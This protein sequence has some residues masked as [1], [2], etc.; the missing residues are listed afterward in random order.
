MRL[1][2]LVRRA[3]QLVEQA[4]ETLKRATDA[5]GY[6]R[7][8]PS[9]DFAALR[10]AAL[11]FIERVFGR[12]HPH[13]REFD[14]SVEDVNHYYVERALGILRAVRDEL[15]GGWLVTA[16]GLIS[17]EVFADFLEMAE[18]LLEEDYKDAAAVMIGSVLEEHLRQ[19]ASRE[20]I[21]LTE[22]R[23]GRTVRKKAELLNAELRKAGVYNALDQ[24]NVT[25]WL[26]LRN[27][28]AHG[29]YDQYIK[30]QVVLLLGSVR[31]FIARNPVN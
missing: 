22:V 4:E 13:Y 27:N 12:E 17:A 14:S 5:S 6:G 19:L 29:E 10:T 20:G 30:D 24:K 21:T 2:D 23:K 28:A 1:E 31:D 16:R 11:S 8:V 9:A 18:H 15:Q 26:G 3:E 25:S 7:H